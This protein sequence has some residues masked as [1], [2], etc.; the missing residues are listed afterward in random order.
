MAVTQVLACSHLWNE[1]CVY[2]FCIFALCIECI[3]IIFLVLQWRWGGGKF[4]TCLFWTSQ[5]AC[6]TICPPCWD[7][8]AQRPC[9]PACC[10]FPLVRIHSQTGGG[11]AVPHTAREDAALVDVER[12]FR[13]MDVVWQGRSPAFDWQ[14]HRQLSWRGFFV[15]GLLGDVV[16]TDVNQKRDRS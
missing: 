10:P 13:A 11:C 12:G 5:G 3:E 16:N 14:L 2:F 9:S 15:M 6:Q 1:K 8:L 7:P 4:C